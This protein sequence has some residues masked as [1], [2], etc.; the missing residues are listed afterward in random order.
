[1]DIKCLLVN[2]SLNTTINEFQE[3]MLAEL[4]FDR[5]FTIK[6]LSWLNYNQLNQSSLEK[7]I[8]WSIEN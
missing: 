5:L 4:C 7:I 8:N 3:Y 2:C 1:M 6:I